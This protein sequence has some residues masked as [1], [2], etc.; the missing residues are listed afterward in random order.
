MLQEFL[1][2]FEEP[3]ITSLHGVFVMAGEMLTSTST[4]Y[5][6]SS[7]R[8]CQR[9]HKTVITEIKKKLFTVFINYYLIG[10]SSLEYFNRATQ[11]FV[12]WQPVCLYCVLQSVISKDEECICLDCHN[13]NI[14]LFF[15]SKVLLFRLLFYTSC[16][17]QQ[18]FVCLQDCAICN[19]S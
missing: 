18:L 9:M 10:N 14:S 8:L 11:N 4:K 16:Q 12:L 7:W 15:S 5:G 1:C 17:V 6:P 3:V 19:M 2:V 13:G